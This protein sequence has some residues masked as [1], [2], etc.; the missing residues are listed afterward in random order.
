MGIVEKTPALQAVR[1]GIEPDKFVKQFIVGNG[2]KANVSDL[3]A[4]KASIKSSPEAMQSV[5]EQIAAH[6]KSSALNGAADEVGNLSQSGFNK[7]LNGIGEEKLSMFFKPD[8]VRQLK[9]IGRVASYEQF[10]PKGSA[11]NNSNTAGTAIANVLDRIGGSSMLS[12]VPLG[13]LL[14]APAQNIAL[15]M[16]SA[17]ALK[18]PNALV[19][20][21]PKQART[22]LLMSPAVFMASEQDK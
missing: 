4:L 2:N 22:N 8:E 5:R 3:N 17:D 9:A 16:R 19:G 14:S 18:V 21:M 12:K 6:L 13:N 15:G 10:Q 20:Y 7:A 11:V 1:D